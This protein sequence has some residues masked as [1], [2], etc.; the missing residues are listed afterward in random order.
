MLKN[1][2]LQDMEQFRIEVA[3]NRQGQ[4]YNI[5][6]LGNSRYQ[7]FIEDETIGTI[8]LDEK[9]TPI[10]KVW[11]ANWICPYLMPFGMPSMYMKKQIEIRLSKLL[12]DV[13]PIRNNF[14]VVNQF[15][16]LICEWNSFFGW[17]CTL[18]RFSLKRTVLKSALF[19]CGSSNSL[20]IS[21]LTR[22]VN[23]ANLLSLRKLKIKGACLSSTDSGSSFVEFIIIV[24]LM[25]T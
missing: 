10:V 18:S 20:C 22:S 23:L 21:L 6:S 12:L 15:A 25:N 19:H 9:I 14:Y 3:N 17:C 16:K 7:I 24:L 5:K 13:N 11:V 2:K 8:Q 1:Y 4:F